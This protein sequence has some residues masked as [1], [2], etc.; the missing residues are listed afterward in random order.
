MISL[1]LMKTENIKLIIKPNSAI[2]GVYGIYGSR[3]KIKLNS[4]PERGR[5]NKE[6]INFISK[7]T[8]IPKKNIKIINGEKSTYKEVSVKHDRDLDL[9]S[10]LLSG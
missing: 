2:S 10:M 1:K 7:R 4:I 8:G 9:T 6:L 3:I 5:A